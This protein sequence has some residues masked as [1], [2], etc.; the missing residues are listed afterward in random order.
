MEGSNYIQYGTGIH[1]LKLGVADSNYYGAPS[2]CE[3]TRLENDVNQGK[4]V[5]TCCHYANNGPNFRPVVE[6]YCIANL[7]SGS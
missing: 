2:P 1:H 6:A 5:P 3:F 7:I 4:T